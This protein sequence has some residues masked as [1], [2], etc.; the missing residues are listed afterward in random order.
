M[1]CV[2]EKPQ[3]AL[4]ETVPDETLKEMVLST[5]DVCY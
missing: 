2:G 1:I 5:V 3:L 4:V